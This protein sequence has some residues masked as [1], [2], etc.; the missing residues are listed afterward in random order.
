MT[1]LPTVDN[2]IV[3]ALLALVKQ[4]GGDAAALR[5]AVGLADVDL[6]ARWGRVALTTYYDLI[7]R[8]SA[9]LGDPALGIRLGQASALDEFDLVS[10]LL[11]TAPTLGHAL[12]TV[13]RFQRLWAEGEWLE[14]G[15][16]RSEARLVFHPWG[17]PREA[18][19]LL[20]GYHLVEAARVPP[21]LLRRPWRPLHA[22]VA[23][24][25]DATTPLLEEALGVPV[26]CGSPATALVFP[27][28]LLDAPM[29]AA[30]RLIHGELLRQAAERLRARPD[31][32]DLIDQLSAHLE[33]RLEDGAL[34]VAQAAA[35]LGRSTRSLQ[36]DLRA[37]GTSFGQVLR[38]VREARAARLLRAGVSVTEVALRLGYSQTSAF[39]RAFRQWTGVAPTDVR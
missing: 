12:R 4:R 38:A 8:S 23:W 34:S 5:R 33:Q 37:Q 36:R 15:V 28:A 17:L 18:H 16:A 7:E 14:L 39:S 24:P 1:R 19:R 35:A 25:V 9:A 30:D 10:I 26:R 22:E 2:G 6:E 31:G 32:I 29:P 27:A 11:M 3:R 20:A 13:L 21:A